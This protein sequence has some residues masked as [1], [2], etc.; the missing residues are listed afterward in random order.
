LHEIFAL[1]SRAII[2]LSKSFILIFVAILAPMIIGID[3]VEGFTTS[4]LEIVFLSPRWFFF[5]IDSFPNDG[6]YEWYYNP[7]PNL[8]MRHNHLSISD[9][10]FNISVLVV[11]QIIFAAIVYL[12]ETEKVPRITLL[13]SAAILLIMSGFACIGIQGSGLLTYNHFH[14]MT[15][16][17]PDL[18]KPKLILPLPIV[19]LTWILLDRYSSPR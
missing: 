13:S 6:N 15:I 5:Y 18:I 17:S 14:G 7:P 1:R 12:Y 19:I 3:L 11:A 10:D 2:G 16:L 4:Y 8:S 9:A